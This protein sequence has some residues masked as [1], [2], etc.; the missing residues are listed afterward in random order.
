MAH[1]VSI[2]ILGLQD[3][4]PGV[5]ATLGMSGAEKVLGLGAQSPISFFSIMQWMPLLPSTVCVTCRSPLRL[6]SM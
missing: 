2:S 4:A 1:G 6:H 5:G 3:D